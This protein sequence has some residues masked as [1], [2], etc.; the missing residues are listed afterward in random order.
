M[1]QFSELADRS[2]AFTLN[3]LSEAQTRV[4]EALQESG[5]TT[6]VKSLQMVQL[7]KVISAV[8]MFSIFEAML[9]DVLNCPDGFRGAAE[10][11]TQQRNL[12]LQAR[13]ADLQLAINVLK[14]GRGRSY[15]ALVNK[16][17]SLPFKV[18][19]PNEDFFNEGDVGE[20]STLVE[21]DDAFV[22]GCA[23]VIRE[24]SVALGKAGHRL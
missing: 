16:A 4:V 21:V 5:A 14:H 22:L 1:H 24:V 7:Q 11:L 13:F 8:G 20:V 12:D 19:L 10:V 15:D 17:A 3:A 23:D 2:A 6:L 18:K 9:H